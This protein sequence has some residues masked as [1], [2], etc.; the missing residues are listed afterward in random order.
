MLYQSEFLAEMDG[1]SLTDFEIKVKN[2]GSLLGQR[3]D[4]ANLENYIDSKRD[5]TDEDREALHKSVAK[6][7]AKV[8]KDCQKRGKKLFQEKSMP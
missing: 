3:N 2:L 6:S 7:T 1:R 5:I 8:M 4:L